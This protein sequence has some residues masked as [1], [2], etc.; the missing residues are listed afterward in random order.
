MNRKTRKR[1]QERLAQLDTRERDKLYKR[2]GRM[3]RTK[4]GAGAR[5]RS[6]DDLVLY[7]LHQEGELDTPESDEPVYAGREG[8]VIG[9][10]HR[11]CWVVAEGEV[12]LCEVARHLARVQRAALAVGDRVLFADTDEGQGLV[13]HV[14]PRTSEL[15]RPDPRNPNRQ[16]VLVANVD[17]VVV[18][19][20]AVNPPLR[21]G[22]IDR[23]L[24]A[25]ARGGARP[26]IAV[27]KLDLLD[28]EGRA[29][30]AQ[31]LE[32]YRELELPVLPVS[33]ATGEGLDA[34]RAALADKL[35]ALVG[36]S[37]VG[38]SSLLN[39][40]GEVEAEVGAV[41][42]FDGKGR[43]TTTAAR[44]YDL[45]GGTR[46]IDT[47]GVRTFGLWQLD[48]VEL[49]AY[50]A[51]FQGRGCHYTDCTHS[52]EPDCGVKVAV[53]AGEISRA[54]YASYLRIVES[55]EEGGRS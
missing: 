44:L 54:R 29:A 33:A 17:A 26:V 3:Y 48:P 14:L 5:A 51:E 8:L 52:H 12:L 10:A 38:K 27:N 15:S 39:A 45:G 21:P 40:L 2:A 41:R 25:T 23:L 22:L 28:E 37:G 7:L 34:L 49:G 55:L 13:S 31:T 53:E 36:H 50:F 35:C 30:L 46:L 47:P 42:E 9:V 24:V 1:L 6:L 11:R 4:Q 18:V 20:A 16:R 19:V 43:H 32:P